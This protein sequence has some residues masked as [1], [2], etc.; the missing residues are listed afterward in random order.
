MIRQLV[1]FA[2]V[3]SITVLIAFVIYRGIVEMGMSVNISKSLGFIAGS[4]F[5]FIANRIWT[6]PINF[7]S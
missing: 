7:F 3:G 1:V 2:L 5:A 6:F 4:I